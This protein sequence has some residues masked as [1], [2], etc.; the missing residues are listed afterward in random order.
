GAATPVNSN[1]AS[2]STF[3]PMACATSFAVL[4]IARFSS[5]SP[6][7]RRSF[8]FSQEIV[9]RWFALRP[10]LPPRVH[11]HP[12]VRMPPDDL[13]N[14]LCEPPRILQYIALRISRSDQ[15]HRRL[16]PQPVLPHVFIP[17]SVTGH[18]RRIRMQCHA[19]NSRR[20]ACWRAKKIHIDPFFRHG[21]LVRQNPDR[22]PFLQHA[23][24]YPRRFV[25]EDR[26]VTRKSAVVIHHAIQPLVVQRPRH[27]MQRE[28]VQPMRKRR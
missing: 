25:L 27:V 23:K 8:Y 1:E 6:S 18:H 24:H 7:P 16:E 21:V 12:L 11:P 22:S 13:F 17:I 20:C 5:K 2:P 4:F 26:P 9:Q 10:V 3:A 19:R 14:H 15:L 28:A